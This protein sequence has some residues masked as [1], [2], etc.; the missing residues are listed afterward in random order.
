MQKYR[1]NNITFLIFIHDVHGS[2]LVVLVAHWD[3]L[4]ALYN[5]DVWVLHS[6]RDPDVMNVQTS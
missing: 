3:H 6:L 4:E 1:N 5:T 2:E